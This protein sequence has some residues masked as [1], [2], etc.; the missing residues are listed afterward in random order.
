MLCPQLVLK[1]KY[2][3]TSIKLLLLQTLK[4]KLYLTRDIDE[5]RKGLVTKMYAYLK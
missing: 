1:T 5:P 2:I 4:N 3:A